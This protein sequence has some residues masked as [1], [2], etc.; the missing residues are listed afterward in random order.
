MMTVNLAIK[1]S[2]L[3]IRHNAF[4]VL[5]SFQQIGDIRCILLPQGLNQALHFTNITNGNVNCKA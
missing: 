1:G 2:S 5:T 3:T 4:L